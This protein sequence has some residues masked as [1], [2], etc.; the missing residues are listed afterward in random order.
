MKLVTSAVHGDREKRDRDQPAARRD[1]LFNGR[2]K[3]HPESKE[4][5]HPGIGPRDKAQQLGRGRA[6]KQTGEAPAIKT[7]RGPGRLTRTFRG[8]A[9]P[10]IR[11]MSD[12]PAKA[13]GQRQRKESHHPG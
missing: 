10:G 1:L 9:I 12:V 5:G 6:D 11:S 2:D 3:N 13:W 4:E 7:L 8:P